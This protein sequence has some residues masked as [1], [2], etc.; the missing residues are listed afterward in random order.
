MKPTGTL[1][2]AENKAREEELRETYILVASAKPWAG[3]NRNLNV[4]MHYVATEDI[5]SLL[6][7]K[8]IF[9]VCSVVC[10]KKSSN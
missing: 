6:R 3:Q 4:P 5:C 10:N 1:R 8:P 2:E 7:L 9:I